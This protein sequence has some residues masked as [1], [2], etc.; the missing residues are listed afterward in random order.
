MNDIGR[1]VIG[2][3]DGDLL[4]IGDH[5]ILAFEKTR[6]NRWR[7]M[8]NAPK[9]LKVLRHGKIGDKVSDEGPQTVKRNPRS[10]GS[11]G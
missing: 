11:K 9:D 8:I 10:V 7:L 4:T 1:L 3:Q 6:G 2:F 5:I